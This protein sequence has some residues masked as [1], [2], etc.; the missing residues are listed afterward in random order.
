MEILA[1][2]NQEQKQAVIHKNG[3]LLIV[4]GAGTGKTTVIT[5]RIAYLIE[6]KIVKPEEILALT[7]TEKAA[8]EMAER[9]DGLLPLGYVDLWISTFHGFGER[10]LKDHALDVGLSNDFKLLSDTEQWLLVKEHLE[11]FDLDYY[12]PKGNPTKFVQGLI[13]HFS[14]LKDEDITPAEYVAYAQKLKLDT[15][16]TDSFSRIYEVAT[17]YAKYQQLLREHNA[18]D[19][20]DLIVETVHLLKQRPHILQKLRQ[21][22]QYILVDEFQDT[23]YAQYDLIKLLAAPHNNLTV[24]ADDDQ[25]IYSF[26]GA[27]MSNILIFK[28]DY[29]NSKEIS[30]TQNYRSQQ[31]I[32]DLAYD[33][34]QHNN[35]NRL[36]ETLKIDKHLQSNKTGQ[37][38]IEHL[39]AQSLEGEAQL[40]LDKILALK[41]KNKKLSWNDFAILVRA[42]DQANTFI[43]YL[44]R[45]EIPYQFLASRGLFTKAVILD[46]LAFLRLLDNYHES[47]SFYR[48]LNFAHW[49]LP[50]ADVINIINWAHKKTQSLFEV[51]RNLQLVPNLH[52][53]TY[54]TIA[55]IMSLIDKLSLETRF[56]TIGE[57]TLRFLEMSGYLKWLTQNKKAAENILYLNQFYKYIIAFE[58]AHEEKTTHNFVYELNS[59]IDA[60]EEGQLQPDFTE[61]PEAVKIMTVHAAKGLEFAYVFVVNL[62]DKRFPSI[63]RKEAIPIPDEIVKDV[64]PQGDWHLEEER[65]LFYVAMTR[66]KNGLFLTSGEDYG[67]ARKKKPS[68][69]LQETGFVNTAPAPSGQILF[70]NEKKLSLAQIKAEAKHLPQIF[71]FTQ[72][73]AYETCP[74]QYRFAFLLKVPTP[75]KPSFSFGKTIHNT[76]YEFFRRLQEG[77]TNQQAPLFGK[78]A[79]KTPTQA[80]LLKIYQEKWIDEWYLSKKNR[81]EYFKKGEEALKKFYDLNQQNWP[82]VL[83]LEKKFNLKIGKYTIKGAI[84]R[85]DQLAEGVEIVDYKT[86]NFPK[87]GKKDQ[88]QLYL[89]ALAVKE[90]LQLTPEKLSYYFIEENQPLTEEFNLAKMEKVQTWALNLI[91]KIL[92]GNFKP[93]PGFHCRYCDFKEICEFR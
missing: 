24:V 33:F 76:L 34:I 11:E 30:L 20:G 83:Y 68:R 37:A 17:A 6:E 89:Y 55:S 61:G 43:P 82:K 70:G 50:P 54:Q 49:H 81:E 10:I 18:F 48:L 5:R 62:V 16:Q 29:P 92:Q 57:I 35:P 59:M 7:F 71:S 25:S 40:V 74:W 86:G 88:E 78:K 26:R 85:L 77:E 3:P 2:L 56:K 84:D 52:K 87:T 93:T 15:D 28:K 27:A 75:S 53:N 90:V 38:L 73:K 12:R 79:Q 46:L 14:R 1:K 19:F 45:T 58:R 23:N 67:G 60:G 51:C 36:E 9:V 39:H 4:A 32:L 31:A 47:R 42:N 69:F 41:Q 65:R 8:G 72:L 21:Q 13:A 44:E 63:A 80:E 64:L 66:A 22:F 91:E